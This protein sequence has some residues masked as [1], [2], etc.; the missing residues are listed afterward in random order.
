MDAARS[1]GRGRLQRRFMRSRTRLETETLVLE[2]PPSPGCGTA[3]AIVALLFTFENAPRHLRL[4]TWEDHFVSF[5]Y[6]VA[7]RT[8]RPPNC[9]TL[10]WYKREPCGFL[11]TAEK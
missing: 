3:L 2:S 6:V 4:I 1:T 11:A 10:S 7:Y 8:G 5:A 9:C